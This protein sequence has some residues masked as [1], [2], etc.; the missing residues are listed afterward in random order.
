MD[1]MGIESGLKWLSFQTLA[2]SPLKI[3]PNLPPKGSRIVSQ[4]IFYWGVYVDFRECKFLT[5]WDSFGP[6]RVINKKTWQKRMLGKCRSQIWGVFA[7]IKG[8]PRTWNIHLKMV[9]SIG[10]FQIFTWKNML[11]HQTSIKKLLFGVPGSHITY[12]F[13]GLVTAAVSWEILFS[14]FSRARGNVPSWVDVHLLG[15]FLVMFNG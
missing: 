11:S 7:I 2:N 8:T 1:G 6:N 3:G 10:W 15:H 14:K 4:L 12:R 13:T 5:F 9:V